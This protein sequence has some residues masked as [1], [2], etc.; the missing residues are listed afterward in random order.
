MP[1]GPR[2]AQGKCRVRY[3][4]TKYGI[5]SKAALLSNESYAELKPILKGLHEHYC[6]KGAF[7]ELLVDK[8]AALLWRYRR[9]LIAETAEIELSITFPQHSGPA[10][11]ADVVRVVVIKEGWEEYN[12]M[13]RSHDPVVREKCLNL[14]EAL[15]NGIEVSG[16]ENTRD[17]AILKRLYHDNID[18]KEDRRRN[19][20]T[21]YRDWLSKAVCSEEQR[22]SNA[23]P[24]PER[25]RERFLEDLKQEIARLERCKKDDAEQWKL[26]TLRR[27]V[28]PLSHPEH[29][30][31][32]EA[33]LERHIERTM[34]Q[35]ERL[36]RIRLGQPVLP[37]INLNVSSS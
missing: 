33:N 22:K 20:F 12:L 37:P 29:L 25:C 8:L 31:R 26:E 32:Y 1:P 35:I 11:R 27:Y 15:K 34:N 21:D 23:F 16:F 3:N 19:L 9:L 10:K 13:E 2:T 17:V 14:L 6:P 18:K 24:S 28:P 4:A 7:E 5:F 30:S 36:Q